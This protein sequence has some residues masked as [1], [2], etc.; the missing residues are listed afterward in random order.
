M[1]R[2]LSALKRTFAFFGTNVSVIVSISSMLIALTSL[3]YTISAQNADL[4]YKEIAI[5]PRPDIS[6]LWEDVSLSVK[7]LG[8]GPAVVEEIVFLKD[9]KCV[10]SNGKTVAK[11]NEEYAEFLKETGSKVFSSSLPPMP[12]TKAG[13]KAY[14]V[15]VDLL[16]ENDTVRPNE[17]RYL[18]RLDEGTR[19]Q[20]QAL[21]GSVQAA[22]KQKFARD[23]YAVPLLLVLCSA[24]NR[25]CMSVGHAGKCLEDT[26]D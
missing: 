14:D 10:S 18:F 19:K 20:L 8:L 23:A 16:Q 22:V 5:Q 1:G 25:T 3:T 21:D 26:G 11:W 4:Q 2:I 24:T 6:P 13:Q 12:W 15:E 9:G 7:N 17:N